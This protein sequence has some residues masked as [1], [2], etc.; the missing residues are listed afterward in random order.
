MKEGGEKREI[1][2]IV[3]N[4]FFNRLRKCFLR[5]EEA[6]YYLPTAVSRH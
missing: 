2:Q 5:E 3:G 1:G 4:S 6:M